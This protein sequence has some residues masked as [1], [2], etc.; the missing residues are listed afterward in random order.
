MSL[1]C[2][3]VGLPNVGKST[4]FSAL[5]SLLVK[6]EN[7]PFSTVDPNI[8]VVEIPD[9]RLS[10]IAEI[11]KIEKKIPGTIEFVDI[12]GLVEGAS[13]GEGLGNQFL[14]HIRE[15]G[16]IIHVVRCFQDPDVS[17]P[18]PD[19]NPERDI[20]VINMELML[21]DLNTVEN[22]IQKNKKLLK[23]QDK[24]IQKNAMWAEPLLL[25]I[26]DGLREGIPVNRMDFKEEE[27]HY[28]KELNLL[29]N[30][31]VIYVCNIDEKSIKIGSEFT[32]RVKDYV[33]EN[34]PVIEVCGK[35]ERELA[36][37]EDV[38]ERKELMELF[39]LK[40]PA[41]NKLVKEAARL[42]GLRTFFTENGKEVRAWMIREGT[43]APEASGVI[44]SDFQIGFIKAE[45][46]HCED[47]F[48]YG[49]KAEIK[50]HG[51]LRFEGKDYEVKD[52]D[53]IFFH[54]KV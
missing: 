53:V 1:N 10:R 25:K 36:L 54:F 22:R 6:V 13:K 33:G 19:I 27:R 26:E 24:L 51:K 8:G 9:E 49:S 47:L 42:L 16:I 35:V 5:T 23:S 7:Y 3:I 48:K 11:L 15:V 29:T 50:N 2:G 40:E 34:V 39:G 41:L 44:H 38:F 12:A 17:H 4:L 31:K 14:S 30:K 37:I 43:K 32:K 28:I 46:Y 20:D 45:V 52:G 21:A 18:Y